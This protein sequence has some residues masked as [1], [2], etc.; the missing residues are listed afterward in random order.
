MR[1]RLTHK[2]YALYSRQ[3]ICVRYTKFLAHLKNL[4]VLVL[5]VLLPIC[6][7]IGL[8][9]IIQSL[10][11]ILNLSITTGVFPDSWKIARVAP[12]FESG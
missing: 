7:M 8:P 12:N 9:V 10:C 6:L 1:T 3:S 2:L 5:M 11:D 4:K